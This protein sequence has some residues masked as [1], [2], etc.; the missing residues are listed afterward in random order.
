MIA[1][2]KSLLF[3]NR[4]ARQTIT[5][6]AIWLSIS[7]I[8]S[9]VLRAAIII[10]AAR[11]LGAAE[12]GVFSYA[13]GL[14][15]FF[16]IFADIGISQILTREVARHPEKEHQYFSTAFW[17]KIAA[18]ALTTLLILFLA[19]YFAKIEAAKRI[20][21]IIAVITI[22]DGLRE[23]SLGL[24][25]AKEKMELEAFVSIATNI[26][27]TI[28][29]F[30]AL[31]FSATA[32][33]LSLSYAVSVGAGF[34]IGAI[35]SRKY[36][37]RVF[38]DFNIKLL[39]PIFM[40]AYPIAL[41]TF[42][43]AFM[44]NTDLIMLGWWRSAEEIGFYSAGQKII[45]LLYTFPAIIATSIF[46]MLAKLAKNK[47]SERSKNLLEKSLVAVF[48]IALPIIIGGVILASPLINLI[49]GQ[50]YA[51]AIPPFQILLFTLFLI[52]PQL[53]LGNFILANDQ[54][55]KLNAP[56]FVGATSNILF[57]I[58]LI[59]PYGI[60]GC[61]FA[62]IISLSLNMALTWKIAKKI[63]NF[64]LLK[65]LKKIIASAVMMG[66][67]AYILNFLGINVLIT[68]V[69]CAIIYFLALYL[70]KEKILRE[71]KLILKAVK[72]N[73]A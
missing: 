18:L 36:F 30:V 1:R 19:P 27:I 9:R 26:V 54:Q 37:L 6:N 63:E 42:L 69:F 38:Q 41:L 55:T 12:Y 51:P 23:F 20:L 7:Q 29:G 58:L 68:V 10:Y 71:A 61:S 56:A 73:Q 45:Q 64:L 11:T 17:L 50:E 49:Y 5:K 24:F 59:P 2:I 34:L 48:S 14:A 13:I 39:K 65:Y 72:G 35:I 32:Q 60:V 67:V 53:L 47:E 21:P 3:Q 31:Y 66:G 25:R 16:T 52:F 57:N 40:S 15:A 4:S 8:G 33:A 46:P 44:L 62:T 22:F 28:F 43:G 70:M